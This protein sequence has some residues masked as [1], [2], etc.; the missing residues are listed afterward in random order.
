MKIYKYYIIA[1]LIFTSINAYAQVVVIAN[2][3]VSENSITASKLNDI[4]LLKTKAWSNGKAIVPLVIKTD[5]TTTQKFFGSLGKS[6]ME[7]NKVWMKLQLTG[8][9]QSPEG[10]SSEDELIEKVASTPGAIGFVS[11]DKAN[12]KVK[13][14]MKIN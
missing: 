11:I 5:N 6:L 10:F 9:G 3:S 7:M 1:I 2:K 14:I 13:I 8:E 12:D 4:Y